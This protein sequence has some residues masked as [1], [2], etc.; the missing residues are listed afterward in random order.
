ML[1]PSQPERKLYASGGELALIDQGHQG[2]AIRAY[3][4]T[5]FVVSNLS[6]TADKIYVDVIGKPRF[7]VPQHPVIRLDVVSRGPVRFVDGVEAEAIKRKL[8]AAADLPIADLLGIVY[9][10]MDQRPT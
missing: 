3:L 6:W 7:C 5:D 9:Q 1:Y 8:S 4:M 2:D 10:K